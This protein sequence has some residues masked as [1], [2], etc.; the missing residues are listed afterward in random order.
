FWNWLGAVPHWVYFEFLRIYQEP[1]RQV[2]IGTSGVGNLGSILGVWIGILRV[3]LKRRYSSASTSPYRAWMSWHRIA[4]VV[5]C[6]SVVARVSG[7]RLPLGPLG[8]AAGGDAGAG[9][10]RYRGG[11]TA[12]SL[13]A[14][15]A[16]CFNLEREGRGLRFIPRAGRPELSVG[17]G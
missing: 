10:D 14:E 7:G 12:G 3:R 17:V 4:G 15:S 5:G 11:Q 6:L 1:W 9:P 2:V 8:G 13:R 16:A